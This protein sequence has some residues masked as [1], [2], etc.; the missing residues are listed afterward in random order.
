MADNRTPIKDGPERRE[1][2]DPIVGLVQLGEAPNSMRIAVLGGAGAMGGIFGGW[3]QRAGND[4]V[5]VDVS[6][7]A[8]RALN[9]S[10]LSIDEK[11]GSQSLI[12]VRAT[13]NPETVGP[14]DLVMNFV[15]C[16]H[17]GAAV[18]AAKPMLGPESAVLTLQTGGAM[19]TASPA[20][21]DRTAS[22]LAS[23]ITAA[24]SSVRA[25]SNIP[26]SA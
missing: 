26:V 20:S 19:R 2:G 6:K 21:S 18:S 16:Y 25:A 3:L 10:G 15:K 9:D 14:V 11:D 5:L 4:L 17:T 13:D 7:D 24:P 12:R 1:G 23:P 8:I 22:L